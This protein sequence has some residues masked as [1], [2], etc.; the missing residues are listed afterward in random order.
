MIAQFGKVVAIVTAAG[1]G[2]RMGR[3]VP[4]QFLEIRGKPIFIHTLEKLGRCSLVDGVILVVPA[5]VVEKARKEVAERNMHK[6][7][8]VVAGGV[9]RRDSVQKGLE[10]LPDGVG[11]VVVH[12]AVRPCVSVE[13]IEEVIEVAK[14]RGAAILAVSMKDTVKRGNMGFVEATLD[15][16]GLWCV[17]TPQAF[18]VDWIKEG[19][20]RARQDGV[21][22]TD[23]AAL[24]ER[25]GYPVHIVEGED[26]NIK[27][28]SPADLRLA[29][30]FFG[31]EEG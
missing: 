11:I 22:A 5:D 26:K 30:L 14:D 31:E 29:E 2:R 24:V 1:L 18:R 3:G 13:K 12:D 20:D 9:E 16:E 23:D 17:Q 15:R 27:I 10:V 19:H 21:R 7:G 8:P 6:V 4:K 28:T 25:L